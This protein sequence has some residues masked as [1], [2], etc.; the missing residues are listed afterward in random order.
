[1]NENCIIVDLDGTMSDPRHRL[2]YI[3]GEKKDWHLFNKSS[4]QD[5]VN[6]WCKAIVLS[7]YKFSGTKIIFLTGRT[8]DFINDTA[9]WIKDKTD[10][11]QYTIFMRKK[12]DYR[13][14]DEFKK[15]IYETHIKDNYNVLFALD[16]DPKIVKMWRKLGIVCLTHE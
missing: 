10:I 2:H 13:P 3:L 15:E 9:E 6:I 1:M 4:S 12:G 5:P 11:N 8:E 14:A 7:I 16:D